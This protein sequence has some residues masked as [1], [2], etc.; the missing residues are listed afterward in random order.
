MATAGRRLRRRRHFVLSTSAVGIVLAVAGLA[1]SKSFRD[2]RRLRKLDSARRTWRPQACGR[3]VTPAA[4]QA[5]RPAW[6]LRSQRTRRRALVAT[7]LIVTMAAVASLA[8]G[9][10]SGRLSAN[11]ASGANKFTAVT[12]NAPGAGSATSPTASSLLIGWGAASPSNPSGS[13]YQ[14][15]TGPSGGPYSA[16][17]V[18]SGCHAPVSGLSCTD[19]GLSPNTTYYYVV[20]A[21]LDNWVSGTTIQFQG[22]TSLALDTVAFSTAGMYT[23]SVPAHVTSFTFTMNGAGGGGGSNGAAGGA[24]GT[25]VGT[26]TIPN[27]ANPTNFTVI[28]GGGG[29]K[30]SGTTAGAGGTSGAGCAAGG[31]GGA[32]TTDSGG[33]GGGSTCIYLQGAPSGMIVA[34]GG[35]GGGQGAVTTGAGGKGGGGP[36][37]NP[38]TDGGTT[39]NGTSNGGGGG[40]GGKT[41]TTTN[42]SP[43]PVYNVANTLG[44]GGAN[45]PGGS[46]GANGG[47]C[48]GGVCGAGGAGASNKGGA[49]GGGGGLASGGG[50][51]TGNSGSGSTNSG[52]GGGGSAYTGGTTVS[53]NTYGV[54]VSSA[55]DGGG[56][57]GGA[58][59]A[60]GT[61]GSV[62]FTGVGLLGAGV[63]AAGSATSATT[64]VT[65]SFTLNANTTYAVF[66][67]SH[68]SSGDS[69][70]PT[71]SSLGSP[72]FTA[73][74]SQQNF[75]SNVDHDWAW[76]LTGAGSTQGPGSITVT[77]SNT[78]AQAYVEVVEL[79]GNNT[80][81]PIVT[82]NEGFAV[83]ASSNTSATANL[84]SVSSSLDG[85]LIFFSGAGN[86]GA[87]APTSSAAAIGNLSYAAATNGS[88]GVYF[89]AP[90]QTSETLTLG[91][92]TFWGTIALEIHH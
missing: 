73:I 14:V 42:M 28:V 10:T 30:G 1:A 55:S 46:S 3:L 61:A 31:A 44:G 9:V 87:A 51:G 65:S 69:A 71:S 86:A 39:L 32:G 45:G 84:S 72:V 18:G 78:A 89:G 52:G 24:G 6:R 62:T 48:S 77:F 15:L 40:G 59:G 53:G 49:G 88:Q 56:S 81:S 50:G 22:T 17:P 64:A 16:P 74:G 34:V 11:K 82:S 76:Y 60:S 63:V 26:I 8:T 25:V 54:T 7:G 67:F 38:G 70:T 2:Q 80:S 85:E 91:S 29:G 90:P 68:S 57:A 36:T 83:S 79:I 20:E 27:S 35:G 21:V 92:A 58:A 5:E 75:A 33:G 47:T 19:S 12:L 43:P 41:V 13:Q 4:H 66:A 23:L 37:S